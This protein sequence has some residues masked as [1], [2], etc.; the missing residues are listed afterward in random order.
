[1]ELLLAL[2]AL[3][4][5]VTLAVTAPLSRPAAAAAEADDRRAELEAAK[6]AKY[7]E[8]RD[9][10][11]DFRLGK[12]SAADHEATERELQSQALAILDELDDLR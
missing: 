11:L 6:D 5:L 10:R 1:M 2:T 12:V 7:R 3:L 4:C 9:A 8:I